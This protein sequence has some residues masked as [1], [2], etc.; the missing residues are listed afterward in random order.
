[1]SFKG[2]A[3]LDSI[4]TPAWLNDLGDI[5][6]GVGDEI[7]DAVYDLRD[8]FASEAMHAG[9][10]MALSYLKKSP[11]TPSGFIVGLPIPGT[12]GTV[13]IVVTGIRHR[14]GELVVYMDK[15]PKTR[16]EILDFFFIF[17][18][19]QIKIVPEI[20]VSIFG[21]NVTLGKG[22]IIIEGQEVLESMRELIHD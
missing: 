7:E 1:M 11:F 15:P 21:Y 22:G 12:T 14:L 10:V 9:I 18:P 13:E 19:T 2:L 3:W 6:E 17:A 5:V 16:K 8:S 4:K 20:D